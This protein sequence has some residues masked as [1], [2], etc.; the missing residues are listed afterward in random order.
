[1]REISDQ[2]R[3]WSK[4]LADASEPLDVRSAKLLATSP[5]GSRASH[6]TLALVASIAAIAAGV[7]A[8]A[9]LSGG[10]RIRPGSTTLPLVAGEVA[11]S[12]PAI[13]QVATTPNSVQDASPA[14]RSDT[15]DHNFPSDFLDRRWVLLGESLAETGPLLGAFEISSLGVRGFDGCNVYRSDIEIMGDDRVILRTGEELSTVL[16]CGNSSSFPPVGAAV[17]VANG[18]LLLEDQSQAIALDFMSLE[19][20][21]ASTSVL[22]WETGST[23]VS[24]TLTSQGEV[25][26]NCGRLG[27]WESPS[28]IVLDGLD[29]IPTP[30]CSSEAVDLLR[31][32]VP[33]GSQDSISYSLRELSGSRLLVGPSDVQSLRGF[34][35]VSPD[36]S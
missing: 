10:E 3:E 7:F 27:S 17:R 19:P 31:M 15:T 16:G 1:M 33:L 11:S 14:G 35:I 22:V 5:S 36:L 18:T 4:A 20:W 24:M 32:I 9:T 23:S 2:L 25:K 26:S 30:T 34:F 6:R 12:T 21:T 29:L 28:S 8:V 13:T